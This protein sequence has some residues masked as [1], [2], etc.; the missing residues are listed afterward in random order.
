MRRTTKKAV[1]ISAL[2]F[3]VLAIFAAGGYWEFL[4]YRWRAA[5]TGTLDSF[6]RAYDYRDADA[7]FFEPRY[8]DFE[9]ANDNLR[10]VSQF[11]LTPQSEASMLDSCGGELRT[12]REASQTELDDISLHARLGKPPADNPRDLTRRINKSMTDCLLKR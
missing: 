10:R 6:K 4:E 9:I 8:R 2:T 3:S 7:I 12:Y 5:Y 1:A 11:A